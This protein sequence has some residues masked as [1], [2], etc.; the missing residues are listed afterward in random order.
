M[1]SAEDFNSKIKTTR[2]F[3]MRNGFTLIELVIVMVLIGI[4]AAGAVLMFGSI[5][6]QQ[7]TD[8]TLQEMQTL[9]NAMTGHPDLMEGGVRS[10]FGYAGDMGPLPPTSGVCPAC[11]L[12]ELVDQSGRPPWSADAQLPG[13]GYGWRGPYI[14][15]KQDDSSRY[16]AL[17]DGWGNYYSYDDATGQITSYGSDG[18]AGGTGDAADITWPGSALTSTGTVT[19]RVTNRNGN[20]VI[21]NDVTVTYPNPASPGNST[22]ATNATDANGVFTL[23]SIPIGKHK[24]QTTVSAITYTKA[25]TV[26]PS[27]S[28]IVDFSAAG[29]PTTPNAPTALLAARSSLSSLNLT[30]T[31]PTLNTDGT[32]LVDLG[33][34]NIYRSIDGG[35]TYPLLES[36]GLG[37]SFTNTLLTAGQR[38]IY[39]MRAVDK[40]GNESA[41]SAVSST[42]VS[43]ILQT[44]AAAWSQ[45]PNGG[46]SCA[47]T[48]DVERCATGANRRKALFTIQNTGNAADNGADITVNSMVITW[49]GTGGT[50]KKI[51]A[52]DGAT[53]RYCN[54]AA[55]GGTASGVT[56][57]LTAPLVIAAGGSTTMGI[58][59]C[60]T[61]AQPTYVSVQFNTSDGSISL[62]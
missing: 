23:N 36:I 47:V 8:A 33:G 32:S 17:L 42:T 26:L 15:A 4:L 45:P 2:I 54:A 37:T 49:V 13:T 58:Y 56:T 62:Y 35:G 61:G 51:L 50:V 27:Q 57:T 40:S 10:S 41:D 20:S 48:N 52:A 21:A 19:G 9:V 59:I 24:I 6:T 46:A 39:R 14:D 16:L 12:I 55:G 43:P 28:V 38:Y 29:D 25:V 60:T 30:W 5:I 7:Q 11:G 44:V 1:N 31:A 18:L 22:T 3:G 53:I 34:Y